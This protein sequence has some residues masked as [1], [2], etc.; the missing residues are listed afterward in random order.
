METFACVRPEPLNQHGSLFG[1][2]LLLWADEYAGMA[3]VREFPGCRFVTVAFDQAEFR[4]TVP[5]GAMLRFDMRR[6]DRGR[7]S[8]HYAVAIFATPCGATDETLIFTTRVTF[9][10]VDGLGRKTPL[11]DA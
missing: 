5:L 2:Q 4:R 3:A 8:V 10:R 11:P 7:T 6:V 9:V 1:G